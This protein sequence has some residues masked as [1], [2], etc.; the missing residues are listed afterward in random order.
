MEETD[1][2]EEE[3]KEEVKEEKKEEEKKEEEKKKEINV[4]I[5]TK[6]LDLMSET[7]SEKI[8]IPT[9]KL[10]VLVFL[11]ATLDWKQMRKILLMAAAMPDLWR[12]VMQTFAVPPP[13][14]SLPPP[15]LMP[16]LLKLV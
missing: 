16:L 13:P 4:M 15:L 3:K 8:T 1:I 6:H 12:R 11:T 2:K 5:V 7:Q 10:V 14:P 9:T